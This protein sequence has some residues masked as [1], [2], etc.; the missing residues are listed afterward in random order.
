MTRL[1]L[2]LLAALGTL[3]AAVLAAVFV[4]G[5]LSSRDLKEEPET[6]F[7]IPVDTYLGALIARAQEG[8]V[9]S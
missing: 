6:V 3:T 1:P 4:L 5:W 2:Y 7:V 9:E 8:V